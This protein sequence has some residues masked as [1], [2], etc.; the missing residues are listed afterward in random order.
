[1]YGILG[2]WEIP[3][4][5]R[6]FFLEAGFRVGAWLI[7]GRM[8]QR[9]AA[10][11]EQLVMP[12]ATLLFRVARRLTRHE[13][14]AE[15]IVQET[16]L[17]AYRAFD[18]FEMREFGIKPWL[19]KI[20]H[21]TFLNRQA[22]EVKAPRATEHTTLEQSHAGDG[23]VTPP[24][25]DYDQLDGEVKAALENLRPDFRDVLLLW[26]AADLSYQEIA[27]V[28]DIPIGTVMS[29]L[30]RAR[31]NLMKSLEEYGRENRLTG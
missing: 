20:L 3:G 14:A 11:F 24:E 13:H 7:A 2:I 15:D 28:L 18:R 9:S 16:L 31:Q 17:K 22:R 23:T 26:S 6:G 12:H 29:R 25:L 19:L 21:N 4:R 5:Y 10:S 8:D 27:D 30:H 1:M